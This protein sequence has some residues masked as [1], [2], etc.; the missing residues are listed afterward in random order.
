M[1]Y[2]RRNQD[3]DKQLGKRWDEIKAFPK[4]EQKIVTATI[5]ENGDVIFLATDSNDI[6]LNHGTV[7]TKRAS[8]VEPGARYERW[9][10]H[11]LRAVFGDKGRVS[12]WTRTWKTLWRVNTSPVGGPIL[13]WADVWG[14]PVPRGMSNRIALWQHRQNAID[15]E[16]KFLN[17]WFLER[18]I[19]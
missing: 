7:V 8:H 17:V 11:L 10:F 19:Q 6:F 9:L 4:T 2:K 1:T 14:D 12:N 13:T 3:F 5:D 16:V 18:G 15:A